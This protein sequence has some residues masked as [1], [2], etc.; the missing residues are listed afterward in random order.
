M[1]APRTWGRV[2]GTVPGG[3]RAP[4]PRRPAVPGGTARGGVPEIRRERVRRVP[5]HGLRTPSGST[6]A[7]GRPA[8]SGGA[9]PPRL[10]RGNVRAAVTV[11]DPLGTEKQCP[12]WFPKV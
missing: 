7:R 10:P 2:R 6:A 4:V 12:T 3:G 5:L 11:G 9:G 1:A 8:V